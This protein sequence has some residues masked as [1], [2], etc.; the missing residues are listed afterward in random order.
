MKK[1][2]YFTAKVL[3]VILA[4]ALTA[5]SLSVSA[6]GAEESPGIADTFEMEIEDLDSADPSDP[7]DT[8]PSDSD[9][10]GEDDADDAEIIYTVTLDANGGYFEDA[11]DDV[12]E[13]HVD[14]AEVITKVVPAGDSIEIFPKSSQ[15]NQSL[16]F[17]GWS[18][19]RDGDLIAQEYE[20]FIPEEDCTLYAVWGWET[21]LV[22]DIVE[23]TEE[24]LEEN[25]R[26]PVD[27]DLMDQ[28]ES[29]EG[30]KEEQV[31][32]ENIDQQKVTVSGR[33]QDKVNSVSGKILYSGSLG[34]NLTW[35]LDEEGTMIIT[36]MGD[37][38]DGSL[39]Y[40]NDIKKVII[41]DGVTS[42]GACAFEN[43]RIL[44]EK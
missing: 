11:W 14:R 7:A 3:A 32:E 41:E 26:E 22:E 6:F 34:D 31:S 18:L 20:K 28:D 30:S 10:S 15:D 33:Q 8:V 38:I 35:T 36:G 39:Y 5:G 1:M 40:Q 24:T 9:T 44:T 29:K 12:L 25:P 13:E 2:K 17:Q 42:I 37:M 21:E 43:C 4:G 19:E 23:N 27:V 16:V